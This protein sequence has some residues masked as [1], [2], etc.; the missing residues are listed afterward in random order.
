[1]R[2]A[3]AVVVLHAA[4]AGASVASAKQA[5]RVFY[6][7]AHARQCLI[8]SSNP[9]VKTFQVVPCSNAAHNLEVFA[10]K[11]GG[12]GSKRPSPRSAGLIARSRCL[13]S[14]RLLTGHDTPSSAGWAFFLPDEGAE[15]ARYGDK[16]ICA[17]RTWPTLAPLGSGWHVR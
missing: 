2:V 3:I 17:F 9:I 5:D 12:W 14:Y 10:V 8:A 13:S 1:M 6:L 7:T 15:T 16:I 4:L 11:H